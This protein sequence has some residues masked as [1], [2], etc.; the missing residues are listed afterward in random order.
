MMSPGLDCCLLDFGVNAGT[1][2][3][4]KYLQSMIGTVADGGIGPTHWKHWVTIL[5][6]MV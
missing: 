2:R 1:G 3:S 6:N 4:A 5:Q